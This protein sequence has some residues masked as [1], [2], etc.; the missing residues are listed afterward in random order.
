MKDENAP[1]DPVSAVYQFLIDGHNNADILE[2]LAV[3]GIEGHTA[4]DV[5]ERAIDQILKSVRL[6]P[7]VRVAWCLEAY[8]SLYRD[9]KSTG[10]YAGALR[11]V[12]EISK[13]SDIAEQVRPAGNANTADDIIA[14]DVKQY[15]GNVID[16]VLK[17]DF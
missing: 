11:A 10:D 16:E 2:Y 1:T 17:V 14:D 9:M 8:L 15:L 7:A 6:P 12:Q 13:L 4:K 3:A 5:F